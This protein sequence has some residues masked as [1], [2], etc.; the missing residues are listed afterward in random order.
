M[1]D[2]LVP[3]IYESVLTERLRRRIAASELEAEQTALA[4]NDEPHVFAQHI[5]IAV[6]R[7]LANIHDDQRR[8]AANGIIAAL[9]DASDD[10]L[11]RSDLVTSVHAPGATAPLR[12]ATPLSEVALLTNTRDE[13]NMASEIARELE[14]A[15]RVDLLCAFIRFAGVA[16]IRRQLDAL[17]DRGVQP[18]VITT[19]YRGATER[20]ALDELVS[21]YGAEVRVRYETASTRLHAKAWLFRR[22]S[23]FD[24]GYVGSSN[25]SRSALVDGLEWN[26]RISNV[27]TPNLVRKFEA[28]FDTYWNDPAFIPYDPEVDGARLDKALA[29]AGGT[30]STDAITISGLDVQPYPHQE[31]ILE[32]LEVAREVHD[33][34]RNLVVAAT[35][36]GKTV[37]AALDYKRLCES[38][39][40]SLSLLFV[41]HRKEILEQSLRK[42]R[43]VLGDGD[44]GELYVDGHRPTQWKHVFA[45]I[46]SLNSRNTPTFDPADFDVVVVDEFHHAAAETYKALLSRIASAELLGLTATPERSDTLD[47]LGWFG[48]RP[49]YE[50]RLWDALE[51]DLL[52]PFHYFGIADNTDLRN[53]VWSRGDYRVSDLEKVYTGNDARTRL[54]LN[55]VRDHVADPLSMRALGFCVSIAHA[56]YMAHSFS[57]QGVPATAISADT[58]RVDRAQ[59]FADL[60]NGTVKCLFAVD[61]FN[62]GVDIPDVDTLLMLRPTQSATVFLQQLGRGLRRSRN[63]AVLTVLDFIGHHR[64]EFNFAPRFTAVTG[65]RGKHLLDEISGG[66]PYLPG[67]S[68]IVLDRQSQKIV[69]DSIKRALPSNRRA[70]LVSSVR[71]T[72][73]VVLG[74]YLDATGTELSDIY[75][76][77]GTRAWTR[78]L[79][80]AQLLTTDA[81]P[82]ED[83]LARRVRALA[84][85]DDPERIALYRRM[86]EP[87]APSYQDLSPREQVLARM[88]FFT[89]WSD[90]GGFTS[91]DAGFH[92]LRAHRTLCVEIGQ[93]FDVTTAKIDHV[94]RAINHNSDDMPLYTHTH[95]RR[96]EVLAAIG[97]ANL[98]R[99]ARGQAGGVTWYD[100]TGALFV[101]LH[102]NDREFSP[103]TMYRDY[104]I[105]RDLFHWE[106]P[107]NTAEDSEMG[108][109]YIEQRS[110]GCNVLL[111][112]RDRTDGDFGAEPYILLGNADYVS[113]RG[114][115]PIAITWKLRRPMPIDV[116]ESGSVVAS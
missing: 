110:N 33:Q 4:K 1:H 39:G 64:A 116:S 99:K 108:R 41:A 65:V 100:D 78:L 18:R 112:V 61:V 113:H 52:C 69:L 74:E 86:V 55:A 48:G 36:T 58:T 76:G 77:S 104:P 43:E 109:R 81:G 96:E 17:R 7:H 95:Y 47:I 85:V 111:F 63:K 54:I 15:D 20:R 68:R 89:L 80:D 90:L 37:V 50:L 12:P 83:S 26:V 22:N 94:P 56:E 59:A 91:Y 107:N 57:K 6:E 32:A 82:D 8:D 87:D 98:Q 45:S 51:Q 29:A 88:L 101:T 23:G 25:L 79:R 103:T 73:T 67:A 11:V 24:T 40:R 106:S 44:F 28:T 30:R 27:A 14:S 3:G 84:H 5:A 34:H 9:D 19:T 75:A 2:P 53:I 49:T 70:A 115:R 13:P 97:F 66:F 31:R 93:L 42:Y 72:N 35:G 46:Q 62:E 92:Y 21:R 60:R 102:K 114:E 10:A 16:V 105:S 38:A 71:E